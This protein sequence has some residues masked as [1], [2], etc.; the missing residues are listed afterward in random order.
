[1]ATVGVVS[2]FLT[3]AAGLLGCRVLVTLLAGPMVSG[4]PLAV[5]VAVA[6]LVMG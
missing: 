1:M 3:V 4:V 2:V 6:V 5:P